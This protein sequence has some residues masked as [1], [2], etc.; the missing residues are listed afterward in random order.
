MKILITIGIVLLF[1][2]IARSYFGTKHIEKPAIINTTKIGQGVELHVIA[3]SIQATVVVSGSQKDA[4]SNWFRQLAWYIFW[5]NTTRQSVAMT[6]PVALQKSTTIAMTAPVSTQQSGESYMVSFTMPKSYTIDTL[7]SPNNSAIKFIELPSKQYYV[8][9][10]I[11]YAYESRTQDQLA[12]FIKALNA[13]GITVSSD[14]ILN[15]YN[16]PWTMPLMRHNEWRIE[17]I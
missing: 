14:P 9:S 12:Q 10:F 11:W 2:W 17:T 1:L 5:W 8:W 4:I 3:P 13:Q 6:A 7:P 15:Q 16:D